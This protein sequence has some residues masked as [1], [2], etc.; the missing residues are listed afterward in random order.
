MLGLSDLNPAAVFVTSIQQIRIIRKTTFQADSAAALVDDLNNLAQHAL[1]EHGDGSLELRLNQ[2]APHLD[3]AMPGGK[4][5]SP[6]T[7]QL[8]I[9]AVPLLCI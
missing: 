5:A 6:R 1:I 2:A 8:A 3:Q 7:L 4:R 9:P